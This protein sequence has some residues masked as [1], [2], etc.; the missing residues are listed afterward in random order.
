MAKKHEFHSEFSKLPA[1][2][3]RARELGE[4][5]YFTGKKCVKGH[6]S[7]RYASS[8]N[9]SQCIAEVRGNVEIKHKGKSSKRSD[10]NHLL[11][12][13]AHQS[14]YLH[15]DSIDPCPH[16]HYKKFV[17]TNNCVE[18]S[19]LAMQSRAKNAKWSR[20][21]KLYGLLQQDVELMLKN[22]KCQCAICCN[23]ISNGYHIDHCHSTGKV[24]GLLCQK[25]NQAIGLLRE[26]ELLCLKAS[27]YI[28][29]HN[30]ET[31]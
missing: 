18:C 16:G 27:Q 26:S 9:C 22:Q 23:D 14:G 8:G 2:G 3:F 11:A 15:Y 7:P 10:E 6:L 30:A 31:S 24:R 4:T 13:A 28:E 20:V 17:T 25:C 29:K 21:F 1:T 19:K 5:L 12:L